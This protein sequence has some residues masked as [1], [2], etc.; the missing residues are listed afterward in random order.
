MNLDDLKEKLINFFKLFTNFK[1]LALTGMVFFII[2][3]IDYD[4]FFK[5]NWMK[6]QG[7]DKTI[8]EKKIEL[9]AKKQEMQQLKQ[10][11]DELA[12][13]QI[14]IPKLAKGESPKVVAVSASKQLVDLIEGIRPGTVGEPLP[15]EHGLKLISME[16]KSTD[17]FDLIA[18]P[19][20]NAPAPATPPNG[21]AAAAPTSV[22]VWRFDY[23][24]VVQG[25]YVALA[26]LINEMVASKNLLIINQLM[27]LPKGKSAQ[28]GGGGTPQPPTFINLKPLSGQ[29]GETGGSEYPLEMQLNFSI[30]LDEPTG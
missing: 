4:T 1:V 8:G 15:P 13:L 14:E 28:P 7:I 27:I 20:P 12:G 24:M 30:Y 23:D 25:T 5:P 3:F 17:Q 9:D 6:I 16:Q 21:Q 19:D 11:Q 2:Y 10:W 22:K 18:P 29:P 26:D